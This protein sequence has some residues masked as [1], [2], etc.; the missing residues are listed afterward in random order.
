M[1]VEINADFDSPWK[2]ALEAF[3]PAFMSFFFPTLHAAID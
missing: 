3:F 2:E 1:S